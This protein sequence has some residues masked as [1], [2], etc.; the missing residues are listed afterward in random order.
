MNEAIAFL[1]EYIEKQYAAEVAKLSEPD[2]KTFI[3]RVRA[4]DALFE[5][6][7]LA[8]RSGISRISG[9]PKS[10]FESADYVEGA[11]AILPAQLHLVRLYHHPTRH[12]VY[13]RPHSR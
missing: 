9:K 6:T 3:A 7:N 13:S 10:V 11:A 1:Q 8:F 4:L 12:D 2:D 5:G